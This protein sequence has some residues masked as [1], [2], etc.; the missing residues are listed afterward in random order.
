MD[1][2]TR[3]ARPARRFAGLLWALAAL[4]LAAPGAARAADITGT[5][6]IT[7]NLVAQQWTFTAGTGTLAGEGKGG[8]YTWP[9]AG[10]IAGNAVSVTTKYRETTYTAYFRGTVSADGTT[11]SGLWSTSPSGPGLYEWSAKRRGAGPGG[12]G[13]KRAT[14]TRVSCNRGPLPTDDFACTVEVGDG[15]SSPTNPT[16]TVTFTSTRGSFRYGTQCTLK[17]TPSS[18][19]V[20][21]CTVTWIPPVGGLEAGN[22][23]D[24]VA[25]YPGD[26]DHAASSGGTQPKIAIGYTVPF[27]PTAADCS[28]AAADAASIAKKRRIR[29]GR[30]PP[31]PHAALNTYN[32]STKD[33]SWGN[34][35]YYNAAT[36]KNGAAGCSATR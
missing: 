12:G 2:A 1:T 7:G 3:P 19:S 23:P 36:C 35:L 5:W 32:Y 11:M 26:A 22:Q 20:S 29:R 28:K 4:A 17:P 33:E 21:A 13:G 18:G 10:T 27:P 31:R 25:S 34:W 14:G 30:E 24:L 6:D 15:G 8:S 9:M 16:G